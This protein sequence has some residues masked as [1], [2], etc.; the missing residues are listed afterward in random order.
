[1][2]NNVKNEALKAV[3]PSFEELSENDMLNIEG[4]ITPTFIVAS[5][6]VVT[7]ITGYAATY[8]IDRIFN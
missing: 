8:T 1:M 6:L 7:A 3:G 5:K 4:E 2:N